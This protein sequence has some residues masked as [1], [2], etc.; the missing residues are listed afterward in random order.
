MSQYDN[1]NTGKEWLT[2]FL[3][4]LFGFQYKDL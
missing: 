1:D 4:R 3:R 2:L